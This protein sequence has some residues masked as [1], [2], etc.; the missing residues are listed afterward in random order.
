M[1]DF[2]TDLYASYYDLLIYIIKNRLYSGCPKDLAYD[3][4]NEVFIVALEKH[5]E[6]MKHENPKGWL[7]QTAKYI[8]D[9]YNRTAC[10]RNRKTGY[11]DEMLDIPNPQDMTEDCAYK[12]CLE[13]NF[14]E[15]L[16]K[17]LSNEEKK[18]YHLR[19]E[20]K[21]SLQAISEE[22]HITPNA[23]NTR[24]HRLREKVKEFIRK[25]IC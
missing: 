11:L 25:N 10:F 5:E 8:V 4:L 12:E 13:N 6:L 17:T 23:V 2:I 14:I 3:C 15:Y 22:L 18:L 7:T 20:K 1:E 16:N 19:Y 24:L 21:L 9:N